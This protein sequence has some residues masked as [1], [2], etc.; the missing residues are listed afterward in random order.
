MRTGATQAD[1]KADAEKTRLSEA[2][3]I[4]NRIKSV[5]D[6][7]KYRKPRTFSQIQLIYFLI[8]F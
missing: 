6:K 7:L 4:V 5:S 3:F 1:G 2:R 8:D